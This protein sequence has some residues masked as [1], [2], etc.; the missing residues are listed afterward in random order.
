VD[1]DAVEVRV[2]GCLLEK[3]RTT[4]D[5]YP[6]SLNALRLACNQSTARDPVVRYEEQDIRDALHRLGRRRWTRLASG[7]GSRVRKYRHLLPEALGVDDEELALLAVLMLRGSQTPGELKGRSERQYAFPDLAAV[8][9]AL[10]R[11]VERG[12]VV[13]HPRRPG[14][15]EDRY[16]QLLGGPEGAGAPPEAADLDAEAAGG[17]DPAPALKPAEDRLTRVERELGEL[18]AELSRLR[19]ALGED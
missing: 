3:Q 16:Q 7:A 4:P 8:Q 15:K 12:Y 1:L 10:A 14:Q 18:R 11:L 19:E 9:E 6:L 13:R 17:A 5:A 2:I